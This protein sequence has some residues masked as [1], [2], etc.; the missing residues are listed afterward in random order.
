MKKISIVVFFVICITLLVSYNKDYTSSTKEAGPQTIPSVEMVQQTSTEIPEFTESPDVSEANDS[1]VKAPEQ[2]SKPD[3]VT[4]V[5][6][7]DNY[8]EGELEGV[9]DALDNG[10][11]HMVLVSTQK[12]IA[13]GMN[14]GRRQV[15]ISLENVEDVG[16][17]IV[18]IGGTG[19]IEQ[20]NN[21]TLIELL[22]EVDERGGI[23]AGICAG[24][25]VLGNAG[26]LEGKV[27]SWYDGPNT[28]AEMRSAGCKSSGLSV[29]IDGNAITG[30][31]SSVAR[32]FGLGIVSVLDAMK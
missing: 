2:T 18:V 3:W 22:Q 12:G 32:E 1:P 27:A 16:L 14:G 23:V 13:T 30:S 10:G 31:D 9:E 26:V 15:D 17:G 29:T 7:F 19:I 28:N 21:Q 11:Y 25:G 6:A 4:V 20:W 8:H 24:P 5:I